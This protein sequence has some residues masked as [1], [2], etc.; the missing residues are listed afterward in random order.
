MTDT[1]LR[2][3]LK[4]ILDEDLEPTPLEKRSKHED[5]HRRLFFIF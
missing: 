2:L 3:A 5:N 4:L 1:F